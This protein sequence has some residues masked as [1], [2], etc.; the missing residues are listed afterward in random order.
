MAFSLFLNLFLKE[1]KEIKREKDDSM[2]SA[3]DGLAVSRV[4][5]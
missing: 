3:D 4:S 5:S 1:I 2:S